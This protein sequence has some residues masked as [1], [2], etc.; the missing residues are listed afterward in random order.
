MGGREH[1]SLGGHI[2]TGGLTRGLQLAHI[3][4]YQG[5][6]KMRTL[7]MNAAKIW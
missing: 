4:K 1:I 3:A 5:R 2:S 7:S 6:M